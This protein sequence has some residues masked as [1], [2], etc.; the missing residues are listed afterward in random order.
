MKIGY[1]A[2]GDELLWE[3]RIETNKLE[4]AQILSSFG[5][6]IHSELILRDD[7]EDLKRG[8]DY[9]MDYD[10]VITSGGLGPTKDDLTREALSEYY[11]SP[12]IFYENL[13]LKLREDYEKRGIKIKEVAKNQFYIPSLGKPLKNLKG[14]APGIFI[15]R[16]KKTLFSFPGVP[17]EF[18]FMLKEYLFPYLKK[19]VKKGVYKRTYDLAGTFESYVED[20]LKDFYKEF[21]GEKITIL[22]SAGIVSINI[23]T[24]DKKIFNRMDRKLKELFK[25]EIFSLGEKKLNEIIYEILEKKNIKIS[26]AESCTG[27]GLSYELVKVPGISKYFLGG[28]VVYSNEAKEKILGVSGETLKRFGA[29]SSETAS[30]MAQK[31]RKKF[32]SDIGVSITGIAGPEGGSPQKPVGTVYMGISKEDLTETHRFQFSG[33]RERIQKFT[34][35]FALNLIRKALL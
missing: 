12:L 9:F 26:V 5:F 15:K 24:F 31:V 10:L 7:K 17:E 25:E 27:G 33:S 32:K 13:F 1:I 16:G 8:L 20:K 2:I 29:V 3:N 4:L 11:K 30:E 28:L 34:I 35:N 19:K 18:R 21:S 6:E 23:K 14:T 22:A